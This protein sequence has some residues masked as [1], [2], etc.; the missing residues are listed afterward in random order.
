[1][2][3]Q[4]LL[5]GSLRVR[6]RLASFENETTHYDELIDQ[7]IR[8][9]I[10]N[11]KRM[12]LKDRS[13]DN[14]ILVGDYFT[15][16]I[17]QNKSDMNKVES[18]DEFMKWYERIVAMSPRQAAEEL[19][20]SMEIASVIIPVAVLYRKLIE[21]LGAQ[22]IW[23]PGIQLTDGLAYDYGEKK[24]IIRSQ[25]DFE[26]DILM[27]AKNI[28]KRY[29]GNKQHTE[30][31]V[32]IADDIFDVVKKNSMLGGRDKLLLQV[33]CYLHDCGKYISLVNVA[34]CSYNI[35]M[36]TEIIGL[37]DSER[38]II[39]NVVKYNTTPFAYYSEMGST[40]NLNEYDYMRVAELTAILRVSNSLDQ[41]YMQKITQ[42]RTIKKDDNLLIEIETRDDYTLEK[43]IFN[44]NVE[45]FEEIF[46]LKPI[47]KIRKKI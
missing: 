33:A 11:F 38:S 8:K 13:I 41:S 40:S 36:S 21:E 39:A 42:M 5:L 30:K 47:L 12:Y 10:V 15:N 46:D 14:I 7:M 1:M 29:A 20:V 18:R 23:L 45:F 37:S 31:L 2:T 16:L 6:E 25:H 28:A 34:E 9:D 4:N 44:E 35:I 17:F 19:G 43:G 27:A 26:Q 24:K 22:T 3:T 32:W